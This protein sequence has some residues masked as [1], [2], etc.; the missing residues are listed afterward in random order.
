MGRHDKVSHPQCQMGICDAF[1]I[2]LERYP[3]Q[4]FG[5]L[6]NKTTEV[7]GHC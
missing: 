1:N 5:L 6:D 7:K 2:S 4:A 3:D